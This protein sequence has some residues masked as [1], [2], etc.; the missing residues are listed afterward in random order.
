MS[1]QFV[2]EE[3]YNLEILLLAHK[4]AYYELNN[5][6][7]SDYQYDLIERKYYNALEDFQVNLDEYLTNWIGFD[8]NHPRAK[9]AIKLYEVLK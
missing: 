7:I 4:Y 9:E 2:S 5:P 8:Y 1:K 3:I 6:I